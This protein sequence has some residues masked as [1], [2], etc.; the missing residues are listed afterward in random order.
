MMEVEG[1]PNAALGGYANPLRGK[2][3]TLH[4]H[5]PHVVRDGCVNSLSSRE[6]IVALRLSRRRICF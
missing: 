2:G 6:F 1:K 3:L 4:K 5:R